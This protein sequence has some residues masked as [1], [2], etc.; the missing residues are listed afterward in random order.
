MRNFLL[1]IGLAI[2]PVFLMGGFNLAVDPLM[3]FNHGP[4]HAALDVM[5]TGETASCYSDYDERQFKKLFLQS[6]RAGRGVL[7]LGSSRAMTVAQGQLGAVPLLNLAVSGATLEDLVALEYLAQRSVQ[8]DRVLLGLDPWILN[9]EHGDIRWKTLAPEYNLGLKALGLE[10]VPV[11]KKI[12]RTK[13]TEIFSP[14]YFLDSL[15]KL[16]EEQAAIIKIRPDGSILYVE[17]P[18]PSEQ[19]TKPI[20]KLNPFPELEKRYQLTLEVWL[21]DLKTRKIEVVVW[22]APFKP[23]AYRRLSEEPEYQNFRNAELALRSLCKELGVRT[24]GAYDPSSGGLTNQDFRDDIHLEPA[25]VEEFLRA[26][27]LFKEPTPTTD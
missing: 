2:L 16:R 25:K 4:M 11:R 8:Y 19:S 7:V 1:K 18:E 14:A 15:N 13:V 27:S 20:Y 12:W 10:P 26:A 9:P 21:R 3:L 17:D 6:N 5:S 23:A 22:F 24:V